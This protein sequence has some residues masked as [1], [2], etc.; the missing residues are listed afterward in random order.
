MIGLPSATVGAMLS[1]LP[2]RVPGRSLALGATA[3]FLSAGLV[4]TATPFGLAQSRADLNRIEQRIEE[5]QSNI[6]RINQAQQAS[7]ADYD[8]VSAELSTVQEELDKRAADLSVAQAT[9]DNIERALVVTAAELE[10]VGQRLDSTKAEVAKQSERLKSRIRETYINAQRGSLPV[11]DAANAAQLGQATRYLRSIT[12]QDQ[13]ELEAIEIL[14]KQAQADQA[15]LDVLKA[16]QAEQK[17]AAENERNRITILVDQQQALVD[18][19][20]A[21]VDEQGAILKHLANDKAAAQVLLDDLEA[22]SNRIEKEL[23][24]IARREA[25]KRAE[26]EKKAKEAKEAAEEARRN[27][28]ANAA[29][30]EAEARRISASYAP[31]PSKPGGMVLPTKG[32]FT[33]PFGYRIHPISRIRKLHTGQDIGAPTG[34]TIVAA[35]DGRVTFAGWRGGYGNCIIIDHGGGVATLYA[36]QSRLAAGVGAQVTQGQVI[37]YVGS[38]GASTGPHLHWEVRINGSPVNPIPYT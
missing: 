3:L 16:H 14:R 27:G 17:V 8:K 24:E 4:V 6:N 30:L 12:D 19:V 20:Q 29:E 21:K 11:L 28:A 1:H 18:N 35:K 36:H 13:A 26:A 37:G 10:T 22:E 25:A 38:T 7:K 23:A 32:R 2:R 31:K 33:S 9:L 15:R 5:A 34:T